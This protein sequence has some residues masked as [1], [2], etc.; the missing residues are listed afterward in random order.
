MQ[1]SSGLILGEGGL[2]RTSLVYSKPRWRRFSWDVVK[3]SD[4]F[5]AGFGYDVTFFLAVKVSG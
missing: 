5:C 3:S 4:G 1:Y 2:P